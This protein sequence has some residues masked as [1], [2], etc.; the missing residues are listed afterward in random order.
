MLTAS[1]RSI[2]SLADPVARM[3]RTIFD[4]IELVK[5]PWL[6]SAHRGRLNITMYVEPALRQTLHEAGL[7]DGEDA[8]AVAFWDALSAKA[9]GLRDDLKLRT[10]RVGERLTIERERERTGQAPEWKSIY[11]DADGFDVLS[12][13]D[14]TDLSRLR[15]E[16]KATTDRERGS[17]HVT[18][19]EWAQAVS[20]QPYI[21]HLWVLSGENPILRVVNVDDI[22]P[23]VPKN[24]GAG[25]WESVCIPFD[26]FP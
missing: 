4:Y 5:P 2:L 12:V 3:R 23:H 11:S 10:G 21:F 9:R 18:A 15:I 16:V 1:G 24:F 20:G 22:K 14:A 26:R 8:E 13:V 19:N 6:S 17:F 7:I 25:L